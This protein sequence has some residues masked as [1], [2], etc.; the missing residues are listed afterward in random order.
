MHVYLSQCRKSNVFKEGMKKVHKN[1]VDKSFIIKLENTEKQKQDLVLNA[2]FQHFNPW[3]LV[4]KA[5]SVST[6]VRIVVDPTMTGFNNIIAKGEN[7]IGLIFTML[8]RCRC[9]EFIWSSDISK[10]YNQLIMGD[11]S[12]LIHYSCLLNPWTLRINWISGSW[13]ELGMGLSSP[14]DKQGLHW[15]N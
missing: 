9:T 4:L 12:Y 5:D 3:R 2:P 13:L 10:L 14:E 7:R 8:I 6:P 1:L 11:L 15:I